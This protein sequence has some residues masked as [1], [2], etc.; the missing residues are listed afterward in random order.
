M[1]EMSLETNNN[2]GKGLK[3]DK[4]HFENHQYNFNPRTFKILEFKEDLVQTV[5]KKKRN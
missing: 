2:N 3:L 1:K 5:V 4:E